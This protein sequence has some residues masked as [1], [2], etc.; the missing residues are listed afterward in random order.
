[1]KTISEPP[2]NRTLNLLIKSQRVLKSLA[3]YIPYI[4][5]P[6]R[7]AKILPHAIMSLNFISCGGDSN[8]NTDLKSAQPN[9]KGGGHNEDHGG[10][11]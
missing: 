10:N 11:N 9:K 4:L 7:L 2:G 1:M 5:Y 3:R 6:K 8:V